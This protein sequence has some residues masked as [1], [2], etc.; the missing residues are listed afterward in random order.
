MNY[1]KLLRSIRN[2][3]AMYGSK[4]EAKEIQCERIRDKC[5]D[6]LRPSWAERAADRRHAE[7]QRLLQTW[8]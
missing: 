1:E 7:G 3:D 4:G 2:C 8:A 5:T 6:K